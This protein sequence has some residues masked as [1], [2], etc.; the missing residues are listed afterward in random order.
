MNRFAKTL[1]GLGRALPKG[2]P[3]EMADWDRRHRGIL[4]LLW[5]HVI[6]VPLFGI[7]QG[8]GAAH[9]LLEGSFVA[10]AAAAA[11][12]PTLKRPTRSVLA[13]V[14]LMTS[15]AILTHFSGGVIEMHFHF[16]VMVA[17]VTL[18]QSWLPFGVAIGY[19][20]L[21][22]G[23]AGAISPEGVFN[24]PAAI[25][26]PWKW[27]IVHGGFILGES[28]ACLI[29]WRMNEV[30]LESERDARG[31]LQRA[32]VELAEAQEIARIGS[33]EWN[34]T[35]DEVWWSD[36][37]YRIFGLPDAYH[38]TVSSFLDLIHHED[39]PRVEAAIGTAANTG[40]KLEYE[41]RLIRGDGVCRVI[42]T[43]GEVSVDTNGVFVRM[44]GTCQD[45]TERKALEQEVEYQAFH[46]ALTGLANRALFLNRIDHALALRDRIG[47]DVSILFMDLDGFK[48]V[49]DSL[50][51]AAGDDLLREV[52]RRLNES[53]RPSD[54]VARIGGD[55]FAVLLEGSNVEGARRAVKRVQSAIEEPLTLSERDLI[56]RSS[57]GIA[58]AE[59]SVTAEEL[60]RDADIAMYAAKNKKLDRA[61]SALF[62]PGMRDSILRRL[63]LKAELQGAI[64]NGDLILHFQPIID[65]ESQEIKGVEALV[66]WE[67]PVR[68]LVPPND[69]I[70]LA[71]ETGLIIPLGAWVLSEAT[72][73]GKELQ[74]VIGRNIYVA[75][76]L[77]AR[78]LHQADVVE[79][80][81]RAL[82]ES[83]ID[84]ADV[85][86][87]IT[88][89]SL[90]E[91]A[92][93]GQETLR[94]LQALGVKIAI[95]DFGTGYSSLSYLHQFPLDIL[96]I[97][98][99]F[100][101]R[102][103]S[104]PEESALAEALVHLAGIL[105][106]QTVAEGIE[107]GDQL[108]RLKVLGCDSGQGY[109]FAKPLPLAEIK[110]HLL[111]SDQPAR[112]DAIA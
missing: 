38:P 66:R 6:A 107:T 91:D 1:S 52:A 13:T 92:A 63:E 81:A 53:L 24:H 83:G 108:D 19:V 82:R 26:H 95:D 99:S 79:S 31:D 104:G 85:V 10:V 111:A 21:H 106:L 7:Y 65:L 2:H 48:A 68:G 72:R 87:E 86:I 90:M 96:K 77:S 89:T 64:E 43:L 51:H 12:I 105:K 30:A 100:I 78:Q 46:D 74:E 25:A 17:V 59:G 73:C 33:W 11:S 35:A 97:D 98:R 18:Y 28:V 102:V 61:S 8:L 16:F 103:A 88:E 62:E 34:I 47:T 109:L 101:S 41:C 27:A 36:Q 20:V 75:I 55:E 3:L 5:A 76:N 93:T 54:T 84:P 39:R 69:F 14:G 112:S 50:G 9:S 42:H 70:P 67:H 60:L 4:I 45:I 15:S 23:I 80:V 56:V 58:A 32:N 94:Q 37:L 22:H 29:A 110:A 40:G 49:N 57:I 71:E 44:V